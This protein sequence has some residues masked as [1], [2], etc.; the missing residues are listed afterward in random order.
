MMMHE[1]CKQDFLLYSF[2][3]DASK[4]VDLTL[5]WSDAEG[6]ANAPQSQSRLMNDL[7]LI[8]VAPME[9]PILETISR[10]ASP[11]QVVQLMP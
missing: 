8:L 9:R 5:A 2:D 10:T 3:M 6:S 7:D 4:G 11:L 1:N